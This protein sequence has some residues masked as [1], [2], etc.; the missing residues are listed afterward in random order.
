MQRGFTNPA[1]QLPLAQKSGSNF[2]QGKAMAEQRQKP[3]DK[4]VPGTTNTN[5]TGAMN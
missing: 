4:M 3:T 2:A 1:T 5:K